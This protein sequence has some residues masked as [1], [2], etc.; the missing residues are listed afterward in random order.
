M[1]SVSVYVSKG[2]EALGK[3]FGSTKK[4]RAAVYTLPDLDDKAF[5]QTAAARGG[6]AVLLRGGQKALATPAQVAAALERVAEAK[7]P[8][9]ALLAP[10]HGARSLGGVAGIALSVG[11]VRALY[12]AATADAGD[13]PIPTRADDDVPVDRE[14][15][16]SPLETVG[17]A[18]SVGA[19]A[20]KAVDYVSTLNGLIASGA[21][22]TWEPASPIFS[23]VGGAHAP[24]PAQRDT[25]PDYSAWMAASPGGDTYKGSPDARA[26]GDTIT[27]YDPSAETAGGEAA[28]GEAAAPPPPASAPATST[29]TESILGTWWFWLIIVV[30]ILIILVLIVV[31][32]M[33]RR[34][35]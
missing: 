25:F 28:G 34:K 24:A 30:L 8:T 11:A 17:G 14:F 18:T 2:D 15:G 35:V 4:V 20:L 6:A 19:R 13:V 21:I 10:G 27:F 29:S 26:T 12:E 33:P 23:S 7:E 31:M 1:A 3:V 5:L 22:K 9:V 16:A 32:A